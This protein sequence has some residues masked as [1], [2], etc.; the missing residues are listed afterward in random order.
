LQKQAENLPYYF[1]AID[2]DGKGK[3]LY[4]QESSNDTDFY[5][6]VFLVEKTDGSYRLK[7]P[8]KLP[9]FATIYNFN[10]FTDPTGK[11]YTVVIHDDGYILVYSDAGEELWR[12]A[13]KFGGSEVY[14]K[15]QDLTNLRN[16]GD[17]YRWTFLE[18]RVVVTPN[19]EI[20]IPKNSGFFVF[21]S[22]RSYKKNTIY[23]FAW[24]GATLDERWHT[25]ESQNYLADYCY[26]PQRKELVLLEV[27][28][29]K[30]LLQQGASALVVKKVE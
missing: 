2:L 19:N 28:Q 21:G 9:R 7:N 14:F 25:K 27:V 20:I 4:A 11:K 5:G 18:Q 12:S 24:N 3:K 16:T 26:D 8:L 13:D 29:K 30:G 22:N 1:R 15:R 23:A 10:Q 17:Q 6:D